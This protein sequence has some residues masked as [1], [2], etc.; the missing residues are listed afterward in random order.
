ML[1]ALQPCCVHGQALYNNGAAIEIKSGTAVQ[2][3]GNLSNQS[4]NL[5][6]DGSLVVKG[7]ISNN[8]IFTTY[9]AGTMTLNGSAAQTFSGTSPLFVKN[10][11]VKNGN[12][13]TLSNALAVDGTVSFTNG[14]LSATTASAPLVLTENATYN[15]VS[16]TSHVH[17]YVQ[18]RGTGTFQFPVGDGVRYQ[19]R[20]INLTTNSGGINVRYFG[21]D[22][23][24]AT[25]SNGGASSIALNAYNNQEY[26]DIN[27]VGTASGTVTL[28]WDNYKNPSITTS[29]NVNVFKLAHKTTSE[30]L[31]EGSSSTTGTVT[32]GSVTSQ[33]VSSWSPFTL[34]AIPE[35]ALPVTLIS[36]TAREVEKEALL[37]WTTTSETNAS[38]FEVER[39]TDARNFEKIAAVEAAGNSSSAHNYAFTDIKFSSLATQVYYRLRSVDRDGTFSLTRTVSINKADNRLSANIYPNPVE[40]T[41]PVT[42]EANTPSGKITVWNSS[43]TEVSAT[44]L[45][46]GKAQLNVSRLSAGMY[47]IQLETDKGNINK[48]LGIQ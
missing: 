1:L 2:I 48:K 27:P 25:F 41:S 36:F 29:S 26:W 8:Q 13:V 9:S 28:Y 4:G 47:I 40:K 42:L 46:N 10:L 16:N 34:G 17:G 14:I 15:G 7:N 22:A 23:G 35:S 32:A 6:N 44:R 38:H 3:N 33:V 39:S 30:W 11:V 31:N 24:T 21:S 18:K 12:G 5:K 43:G 20:D 19:P 37:Q 45:V